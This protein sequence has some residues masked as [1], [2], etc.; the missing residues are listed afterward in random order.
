MQKKT[1]M[2]NWSYYGLSLVVPDQKGQTQIGQFITHHGP[3][4]EFA[5]KLTQRHKSKLRSNI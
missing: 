2:I 4:I 5:K 3:K 1:A